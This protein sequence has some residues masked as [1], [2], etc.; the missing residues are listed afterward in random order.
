[1]IFLYIKFNRVD[2]LV[3][4]ELG[5]YASRLVIVN[6]ACISIVQVVWL[7]SFTYCFRAPYKNAINN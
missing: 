4:L 7:M 1:M 2:V 6:F 3:K 5:T